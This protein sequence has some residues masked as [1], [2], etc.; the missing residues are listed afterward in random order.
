[1]SRKLLTPIAT[2]GFV[3]LSLASVIF[4]QE[5]PKV[6]DI[7]SFA[8]R[9]VSVLYAG[10][11]I[12]FLG[13]MIFIGFQW[14]T[15][16]GEDEA[17][18]EVRQKLSYWVTGFFLYFLSGTI[19]FFVFDTLQVR[20]CTG[21]RVIPGFN[22]VFQEACPGTTIYAFTGATGGAAVE[23]AV[24][25]GGGCLA[26][27]L[28]SLTLTDRNTCSWVAGTCANLPAL[29]STEAK[30]LREKGYFKR[31]DISVA[32]VYDGGRLRFFF[33]DET[34]C[35]GFCNDGTCMTN[36]SSDLPSAGSGNSRFISS[37]PPI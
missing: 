16:Q 30:C 18:G 25:P 3:F 17:I 5:P 34:K 13:L 27:D 8:A 35:K 11:G 37:C 20:T 32:T 23:G 15:S 10:G 2:L 29:S 14:M 33:G 31:Q 28:S 26:F 1:M 24:R 6:A 12:I 9:M 19:V 21:D 22:L 36:V 4:A 7:S